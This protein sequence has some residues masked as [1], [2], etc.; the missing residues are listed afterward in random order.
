M[1]LLRSILLKN[2]DYQAK[3]NS[4]P[5]AIFEAFWSHL[6]SNTFDD[7]LPKKYWPDDFI[8]ME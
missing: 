8:S 1:M 2:W 7:D 6:L 3:A 4:A 5:A